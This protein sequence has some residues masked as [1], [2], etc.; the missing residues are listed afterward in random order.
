MWR[1]TRLAL[2]L[3]FSARHIGPPKPLCSS[4][5]AQYTVSPL[6]LMT[7]PPWLV[8]C[9][10]NGFACATVRAAVVLV[11]VVIG[12]GFY[13]S[14]NSPRDYPFGRDFRHVIE[15]GAY[16][17]GF[18]CCSAAIDILC[19]IRYHLRIVWREIN[20]KPPESRSFGRARCYVSLVAHKVF[21][22]AARL[23]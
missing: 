17:P 16:S 22:M 19:E 9:D 5:V 23:S 7:M 1:A 13:C 4:A 8:L 3:A 15:N 10:L 18:R 6:L 14:V 20:F 2:A 12:L 21:K 11:G